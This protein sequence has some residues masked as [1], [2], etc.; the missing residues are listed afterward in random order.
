MN[1]GGKYC[2]KVEYYHIHLHG[3]LLTQEIKKAHIPPNTATCQVQYRR[4]TVCTK[5]RKTIHGTLLKMNPTRCKTS[6]GTQWGL[7]VAGRVEPG[8]ECLE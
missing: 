5:Y 2:Y 4:N 8:E 1:T 7:H 3:R 6:G